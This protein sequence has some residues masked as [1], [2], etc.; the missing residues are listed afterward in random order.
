MPCYHPMLAYRAKEPNPETGKRSIVFN[1]NDGISSMS[2]TLPCGQ[3]I[4]CRLERSRQ[5]AIRCMHEASEHEENSFITLTFNN[6]NLHPSGSL[7]LEDFQKFMKRFRKA[8]HPLKIRYYHC[9]EY[10]ENLGRPHHHACIFGYQFPDKKLW[11]QSKGVN[12]YRSTQLEKLWPYGYCSIGDVTFESAA[13]VARY[14]MKKQTGK[15]GEEHYGDL[16][17]PYTTMSRRPGIGRHW[18]DKYSQDLYPS[19][20]CVIRGQILKPPKFYDSIY[21]LQ[22][23]ESM[24]QIKRARKKTAIDKQETMT[25]TNTL[26]DIKL[27]KTQTLKRELHENEND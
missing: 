1:P 10:G 3:C 4:G 27:L 25:R 6:E 2:V 8:I 20:E 22:D 16:K 12:L 13:Y 24:K 23:P 14:I 26:E 9:G 11:R 19:D 7:Q 15:Q 5:W 21:D 18:Y 17:P